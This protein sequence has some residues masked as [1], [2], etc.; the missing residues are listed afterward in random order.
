MEDAWGWRMRIDN[1]SGMKLE[2]KDKRV[3]WRMRRMDDKS[4]MEDE[5]VRRKEGG[6][7]G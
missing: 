5:D 6:G 7:W 1:Q 3:V 2:I 4:G